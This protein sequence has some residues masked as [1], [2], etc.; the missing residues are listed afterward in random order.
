MSVVTENTTTLKAD[1]KQRSI[2][3]LI[4]GAIAVVV[5]AAVAVLT[6]A[7]AGG[8]D[9]VEWIPVG[10]S[11]GTAA[12]MALLA[13]VM[14]KVIPALNTEE[15]EDDVEE[16]P[17]VEEPVEVREPQAPANLDGG[18]ATPFEIPVPA[19]PEVPDVPEVPEVPEFPTPE[20]RNAH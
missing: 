18:P 12:L 4:Q 11:A 8:I 14:A 16:E 15:D 6:P 19:V 10:Y 1:A 20:E 5:A 13:Y 9:K 7:I 3:S 17:V 2:R